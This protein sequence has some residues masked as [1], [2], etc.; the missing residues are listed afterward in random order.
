MGRRAR[1]ARRLGVFQACKTDLANVIARER[2]VNSKEVRTLWDDVAIGMAWQASVTRRDRVLDHGP[3]LGR[4]VGQVEVPVGP[5][6][7]RG[8]AEAFIEIDVRHFVV[9][10]LL[11]GLFGRKGYELMATVVDQHTIGEVGLVPV[12]R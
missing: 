11:F 5:V 7:R 6:L 3:Q 10:A 8:V 9:D 1:G 4:H 2:A 12:N